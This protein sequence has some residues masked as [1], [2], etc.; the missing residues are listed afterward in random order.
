MEA[1]EDPAAAAPVLD[2]PAT[3][4]ATGPE[5]AG[6]VALAQRGDPARIAIRSGQ[7]WA[8]LGGAVT[9]LVAGGF[10]YLS[11]PLPPPR[12]RAY[13]QLTHDGREKYLGGTDGSRLYF[14]QASP[15]SIAQVGINGGEIARLPIVLPGA[16]MGVT[17]IS[18]DGS[19]A[20]IGTFEDGHN[21][22]P[23]WVVPLLG[24]AAKRLEDAEVGVTFSPDGG[25]LIFSTST[26]D[27]FMVRIDGSDKHKLASV[28]SPAS[29][30]QGSP[31]GKV[32]RFSMRDGLWE[33]SSDGTGLHRLLPGWKGADPCCGRWTRDGDLFVFWAGGQ[34]WVLDE[35]RSLLRKPPSAPIQLTSEPIHWDIPIPGRDGKTIFAV[36]YKERGELTRIDPKTGVSRPFLDGIS[37]E[38]VAFSPDGNSVAYVAYPEG[39]LWKA[40]GDGS[41][42]MQLTPTSHQV[43]NPRWS[44]DAKQIL[45]TIENPAGHYE[46]H[47]ISS[48]DGSPRWLLSEETGNMTDPNWS[49]D[50][51][52]VVFSRGNLNAPEDL[53]IVD[54]NTRQVTVVPGSIG[55]WSPRW[56]PDGRY[57][58]ALIYPQINHMFVFDL[59]LQR[60][61]DLAVNGE[62]GFP[63]FTHDS[64]FIYFSRY[65]KDQG[66]FRIPVTG[67]KEERVVD[68][69]GWHL[70]GRFVLSL[71]LDPTDAPLVLRDTGSEDIYALTLERK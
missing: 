55:K 35:R 31:D 27:I 11:R 7:R 21:A 67:G 62:V 48:A 6:S 34:L 50:G 13:T 18:P 51:T 22:H 45:F 29:R 20:L 60:W 32:I 5:N 14:T 64:R 46:I 12:I 69:S 68:L 25:S 38:Y 1:V 8:I 57:I 39:T 4:R 19:S 52:K 63:N 54:L 17:D 37:A 65:A 42:R 23:Q 43:F 61:L 3:V 24:G 40:D 28:G 2:P 70:T 16:E 66:V 9:V 49:P 26:G 59:K 41:N 15:N 44:P 47:R 10:W 56:S 71:S 36:G 58:A 53:R 33:M 30:F